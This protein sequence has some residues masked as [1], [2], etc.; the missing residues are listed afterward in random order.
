MSFYSSVIKPSLPGVG[1]AFGSF[2]GGQLGNAFGGPSG[3]DIGKT[4]GG[5]LGQGIGSL[6]AGNKFSE[7]VPR[8]AVNTLFSQ[9]V[10]SS[11]SKFAGWNQ[12]S[13]ASGYAH[14]GYIPHHM[15]NGHYHA[16]GGYIPNHMYAGSHYDHGGYV[17]PMH[18][19]NQLVENHRMRNAMYHPHHYAHGG[20][21]SP[22]HDMLH[23]HL[24]MYEPTLTELAELMG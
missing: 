4:I 23:H 15:Y 17:N 21:A 2:V 6:A 3:S 10:Q 18:A 20:Y 5:N 14:G 19:Y 7:V 9:P 1:N 13:T 11:V 8:M 24:S 16:H 22:V 12:P